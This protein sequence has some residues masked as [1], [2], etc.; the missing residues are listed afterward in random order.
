MR[1]PNPSALVVFILAA[2]L[3]MAHAV[4]SQTKED[5][6]VSSSRDGEAHGLSVHQHS[7]MDRIRGRAAVRR[8]DDMAAD[9]PLWLARCAIGEEG[10]ASPRGH[11]AVMHV[12]DKRHKQVIKRWPTLTFR[13]QVLG[14][15]KCLSSDRRWVRSM[16]PPVG[17]VLYAP[18]PEGW[19]SRWRWMGSNESS[20]RAALRL[21]STFRSIKDPCPKAMHFGSPYLKRDIDNAERHKMV[22]VDCGD[23]KNNFYR[24]R[25]K[26]DEPSDSDGQPGPRA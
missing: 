22:L 26:T 24:L 20:W 9:A 2:V 1:R 14:Y 8:S 23:T 7:N 10:F 11:L 15:C 19:P 17:N 6:D 18:T 21:A 16:Q 4:E 3:W 25:S 5:G 13:A 12:L